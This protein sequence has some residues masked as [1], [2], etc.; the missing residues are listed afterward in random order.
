MAT[1]FKNKVVKGVGVV[2][3]EILSVPAGSKV[4]AIGLSIANLLVGNT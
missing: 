2:A 4:S 1:F 3:V